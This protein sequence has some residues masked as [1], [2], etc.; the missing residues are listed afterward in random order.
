MKS[1]SMSIMRVEAVD[2]VRPYL[3]LKPHRSPRRWRAVRSRRL[4]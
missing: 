3:S 4:A 1:R 2:S